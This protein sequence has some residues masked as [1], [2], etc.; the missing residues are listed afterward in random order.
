MPVGAR[1]AKGR[2][3]GRL[4]KHS[5]CSRSAAIRRIE[6][7]RMRSH[8]YAHDFLHLYFDEQVDEVVDDD[9]MAE[10]QTVASPVLP[11]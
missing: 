7:N 9:T 1:N 2:P 11:I 8:F 3:E 4:P 5:P 6:F 10:R